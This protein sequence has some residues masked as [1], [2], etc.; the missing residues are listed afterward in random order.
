MALQ[1]QTTINR[2]TTTTPPPPLH[3]LLPSFQTPALPNPQLPSPPPPP[4][5]PPSFPLCL[6]FTQPLLPPSPS[7]LLPS[8]LLHHIPPPP[9]P[10]QLLLL[11]FPAAN[12]SPIA[13]P[14]RRITHL[15]ISASP[16]IIQNATAIPVSRITEVI[17]KNPYKGKIKREKN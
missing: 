13:M 1:S 5:L 2:G 11:P 6:S 7:L 4:L 9:L 12:I 15:V 17:K 16:C 10:L 14:L 8:I 3:L